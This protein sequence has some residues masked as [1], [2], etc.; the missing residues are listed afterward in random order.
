MTPEPIPV[1]FDKAWKRR[2]YHA[3]EHLR[4]QE[5]R[6]QIKKL[7]RSR[8]NG[9]DKHGNTM[10][11]L[12]SWATKCRCGHRNGSH[13]MNGDCDHCTCTTFV[14]NEQQ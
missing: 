12:N 2:E 10:P 8:R 3:E 4:Q 6:R 9:K 14:M 1:H 11:V 13:Y 5:E 7:L